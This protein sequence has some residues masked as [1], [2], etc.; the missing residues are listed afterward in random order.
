MIVAL[1]VDFRHDFEGFLCIGGELSI[2]FVNCF[3]F[4]FVIVAGFQ[5][6]VHS[7]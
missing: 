5:D 4:D 6:F 3:Q 1:E 7:G 2:G